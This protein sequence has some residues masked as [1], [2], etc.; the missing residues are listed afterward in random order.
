MDQSKRIL[1]GLLTLARSQAGPIRQHDVD[2]ADLVSGILAGAAGETTA[3]DLAV[4]A[5]SM[6]RPGSRVSSSCLNAWS[7]T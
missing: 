2:L 6:A 4:R 3:R 5:R 1:D 7:A